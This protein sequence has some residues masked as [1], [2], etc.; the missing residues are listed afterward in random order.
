VLQLGVLDQSIATAG[1]SHGEA[2]NRTIALAQHCERLGYARFWMSEHHN[3]PTIVGSAPEILIAA[4]AMKTS[5]I[6]IGSAGIMLPH[7]SPLKVAEVFRVLDA[8]APGRIDLGLGRAPGSD[9][10]TAF[11]LHPMA[12]EKPEH[13][14]SEVMELLA[15]VYGV[16][17][18]ADHPF[19]K[20]KAYPQGET[21]PEVWIL[22][23]SNYGA[24]VAA[25]FGLPYS[26]AWHFTDG[27]GGAEAI[28]LYRKLYK[29]SARFPK[30]HAGLGVWALVC[31]TEEEA[32]YHYASRLKWQL[33]R[34]RGVYTAIDP[35]DVALVHPY[36]AEE[37]ARMDELRGR[38]MVGTVDK[39]ATQIRALAER[40][41][42]EDIAVVC[43]THDE[44]VRRKSYA[45]LA[46]AFA[47][48]DQSAEATMAQST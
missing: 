31:D 32:Q 40:T 28:D 39:V 35:P 6:R 7:Y 9:G 10:L 22:G 43:W 36:T 24:Q 38:A 4:I 11:A 3:S 27:R 33:F 45:L 46:E 8:L 16:D 1:R 34:N 20:V 12:N 5:R 17:L 13:F 14:P 44:E 18:P 37:R 47:L 2:I 48:R 19:A 42:V 30:P 23:S 41:G 29:P 25:H 26:F 21:K 15:W